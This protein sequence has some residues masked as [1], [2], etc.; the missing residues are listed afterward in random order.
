LSGGRSGGARPLAQIAADKNAYSEAVQRIGRFATG[1]NRSRRY[2]AELREW[3]ERHHGSDERFERVIALL[4]DYRVRYGQQEVADAARALIQRIEHDI[5]GPRFPW[6]DT[7]PFH[8]RWRLAFETAH[9]GEP[10]ATCPLCG[11]PALRLYIRAERELVPAPQDLPGSADASAGGWS[12]VSRAGFWEW[13]NNCYAYEQYTGTLP[14]WWRGH[15]VLDGVPDNLLEH[16]PEF[17]ER[18]LRLAADRSPGA[19]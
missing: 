12:P 1:A 8:E 4:D 13:C 18:A 3:L 10:D 14:D 15:P 16:S 17:L 5:S 11:S 6:R 19:E 7:G 9:G 2:A